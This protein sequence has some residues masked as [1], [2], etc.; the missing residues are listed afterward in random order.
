MNVLRSAVVPLARRVVPSQVRVWV[1]DVRN[2]RR[3]KRNP[4]RVVLVDRILP[5]YS[6]FG[7]RS[8]WVGCRRY[9]KNYGSLLAS[10][11][12]ECWTTDIEMDHAR[13]GEA[14]R[15]FTWDLLQ[16]DRLIAAGT[17]DSV[18][19]NGVFGFGVDTRESQLAALRAMWRILKPG[20]RL[21]LGWNTDRVE[22]PGTFEFV[23]SA[24]VPDDPIGGGAR[25]EAPEAKYA[26]DFLRRG[27]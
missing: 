22:D 19:C 24:F 6:A 20:G 9:T 21:L 16:I 1:R 23:Q 8:L 11:G 7:G 4:G 25:Y 2:A 15:H 3:V 12:G 18:L 26:Y 14:G 17:F 27:E 5:A 10:N 13:W